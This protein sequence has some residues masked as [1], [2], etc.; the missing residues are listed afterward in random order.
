MNR[1]RANSRED[2]FHRAK[3]TLIGDVD[4]TRNRRFYRADHPTLDQCCFC[5]SRLKAGD[6]KKSGCRRNKF[7][8]IAISRARGEAVNW[9]EDVM[10]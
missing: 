6:C 2:K 7:L 3:S 1:A 9:P 8:D 10:A 4:E 5:G